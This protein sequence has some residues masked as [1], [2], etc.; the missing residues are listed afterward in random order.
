MRFAKTIASALAVTVG[1]LSF[2]SSGT[3]P[4]VL[5]VSVGAF[6]F[7]SSADAR[8]RQQHYRPHRGYN[9]RPYYNRLP[10]GYHYGYHGEYYYNRDYGY[11][12]G[13]WPFFSYSWPYRYGYGYYYGAP[14]V[15]YQPWTPEWYAYCRAK[16]RSFNPSTGYYLGYDGVYHFCR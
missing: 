6:S 16:Y 10:R 3:I 14:A 12:Y 2:P 5:A 9:H 7:A 13:G 8:R 4:T 1:A 15:G 11:G